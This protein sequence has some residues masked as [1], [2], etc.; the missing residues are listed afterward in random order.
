[1]PKK[2]QYT[3]AWSDEQGAY[4]LRNREGVAQDGNA[5]TLWLTRHGSFSFRGQAGK[6]NLLKEARKGG[7]GY[8]Y[9]YRR[10]GAHTVKRYAGR[11][12]E[13]T[14]ARLEEIAAALAGGDAVP[15]V[16]PQTDVSESV[17]AH[18]QQTGQPEETFARQAPLLAAKIQPPRLHSA[19]V[20]RERLLARLQ[21][22]RDGKLTLVSGPAGFGKTT[23]VRQWLAEWTREDQ[24]LGV[25]WLS[26]EAGDND[27]VRFWRY[28]IT[29]CRAFG[30]Q[31]GEKTLALLETPLAIKSPLEMVPA[32]FLNELALCEREG[33]LVL[34]D[35]HAITAP[36]IHETVAFLIDHV[37]ANLRLLLIT[38]VSPP[39]PLARL[40]A[41]G[42]LTE[43]EAVDLRFSATNH[44]AS[45][46]PC[47]AGSGGSTHRRLGSRSASPLGRPGRLAR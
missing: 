21:A 22:G 15:S 26:L 41:A 31:V 39:L 5:W 37:P 42:E 4:E 34:E 14:F 9:A 17:V 40:R 12:A 33:I 2:A 45:P 1:V 11:S 16:V 20:R 43:V 38:R 19:L 7:D 3:L 29:A 6:L 32:T 25:A 28:L 13:L 8:W 35:Y 27:P 10:N 36:Q 46:A 47:R 44:R 18:T 23:L 24:A 30:P